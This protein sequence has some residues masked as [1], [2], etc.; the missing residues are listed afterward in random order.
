MEGSVAERPTKIPPNMRGNTD[1]FTFHASCSV[2]GKQ[3]LII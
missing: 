2:K 3:V 1:N